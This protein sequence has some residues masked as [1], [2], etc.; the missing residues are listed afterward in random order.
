MFL[1]THLI[2]TYNYVIIYILHIN[3]LFAFNFSK[4]IFKTIFIAF[5]TFFAFV[6]NLNNKMLQIVNIDEIFKRV[7]NVQKILYVVFRIVIFLFV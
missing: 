7:E 4:F 6:N 2:Y 3:H 5:F 1:L